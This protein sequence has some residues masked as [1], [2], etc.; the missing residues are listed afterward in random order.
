MSQVAV[1]FKI[2]AKD[3]Q[4]DEAISDI[5]EKLKPAGFQT[6]DVGFGIKMIKA[7][8]KFDDSQNSSSKIEEQIRALGSVSEVEVYEESLL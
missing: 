1:V 8:F 7:L 2:Y 5:K 4:F 3:G 6:E